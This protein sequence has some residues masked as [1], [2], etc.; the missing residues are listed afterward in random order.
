M[1]ILPTSIY[2]VTEI[3]HKDVKTSYFSGF[4]VYGIGWRFT[5]SVCHCTIYQFIENRCLILRRILTDYY[6]N[7]KNRYISESKTGRKDRKHHSDRLKTNR[8]VVLFAFAQISF[9]Q[10]N[11]TVNLVNRKS[12]SG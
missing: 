4:P 1:F 7:E 11:E 5:G 10:A 8:T 3:Q 2:V 9:A 12:H 6:S